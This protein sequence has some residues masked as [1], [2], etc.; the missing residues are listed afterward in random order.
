[1]FSYWCFGIFCESYTT[2][3]GTN[4]FNVHMHLKTFAVKLQCEINEQLFLCSYKIRV[5]FF[6]VDYFGRFNLFCHWFRSKNRVLW[7]TFKTNGYCSRDIQII[8]KPI[9]GVNS[10]KSSGCGLGVLWE[11]SGKEG[12][13]YG[14]KYHATIKFA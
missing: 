14:Y 12:E 6:F 7:P 8:L 1:M 3:L 5:F 4:H 11:F 13:R 2:K 10:K 9:F